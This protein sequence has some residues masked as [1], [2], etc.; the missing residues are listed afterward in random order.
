MKIRSITAEVKNLKLE[1]PYS[2]AYNTANSAQVVFVTIKTDEGLTGLGSAGPDE[3]VTKET[4]ESILENISGVV[5]PLLVGHDPLSYRAHLGK[6]ARELPFS[7][8]ARAA[9]DIALHDL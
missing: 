2:I 6:L 8:S 7:P 3:N 9:V 1:H 4:A 5:E